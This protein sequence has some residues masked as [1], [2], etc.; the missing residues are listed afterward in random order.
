MGLG[1]AEWWRATNLGDMENDLYS[2]AHHEIGHAL[3]FNPGHLRFERCRFLGMNDRFR[4][5]SFALRPVCEMRAATLR[6]VSRL[7]G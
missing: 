2:I 5:F 6:L 3:V 1:D 4:P 7:L